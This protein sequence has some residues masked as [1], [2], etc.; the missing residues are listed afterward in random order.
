M[1]YTIQPIFL[2]QNQGEGADIPL[3]CF[4]AVNEAKTKARENLQLLASVN[5]S[6]NNLRIVIDRLNDQV[7]T[8]F[9]R[10]DK[11]KEK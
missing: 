8:K 10:N 6:L 5:T 11:E 4:G 7:K 1:A 2:R 3:S 9:P